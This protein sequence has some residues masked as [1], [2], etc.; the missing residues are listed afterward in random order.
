MATGSR[1][2][3]AASSGADVVAGAGG[4]LGAAEQGGRSVGRGGAGKSTLARRL[5]ARTGSRHRARSGFL[6]GRFCHPTLLRTSRAVERL[7]AS[8]STGRLA[9]MAPASASGPVSSM[10]RAAGWCVRA[11]EASVD[12]PERF[13]GPPVGRAEQPHERRYEAVRG[14]SRRR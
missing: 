8:I 7:G 9:R 12:P 14:R 11:T 13:R 10:A 1:Y 6:A 4:V 2:E 5:G 3:R